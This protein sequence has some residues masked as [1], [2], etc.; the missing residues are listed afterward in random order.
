MGYDPSHEN[1]LISKTSLMID[2]VLH[3]PGYSVARATPHG[4]QPKALAEEGL[5]NP[6][7]PIFFYLDLI[8]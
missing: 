7:I 6:K 8:N 5:Q 3:G 4:P 2:Y 1:L